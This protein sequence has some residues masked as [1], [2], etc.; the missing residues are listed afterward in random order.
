LNHKRCDLKDMNLAT[1]TKQFGTDEA[2][3]AHLERV[4]WPDGPVCPHCCSVEGASPVGGRAGLHR[5]HACSRQFSVIVGTPLHGSHLPLRL[6]YRAMYLML[7]FTEGISSVKLAKGLGVGQKTAWLLARRIRAMQAS[8][9]GLPI[10]QPI[11]EPLMDKQA[12]HE[13]RCAMM[14]IDAREIARTRAIGQSLSGVQKQRLR[15]MPE[16]ARHKL[17]AIEPKRLR[18][19]SS[20]LHSERGRGFSR[21]DMPTHVKGFQKVMSAFAG[22]AGCSTQTLYRRVKELDQNTLQSK[23]RAK[24]RHAR[25]LHGNEARLASS[26]TDIAPPTAIKSPRHWVVGPFA[27][28]DLDA[29][30]VMVRGPRRY[31]KLVRSAGGEWDQEQLAWLVER[32]RIG[33][34]TRKLKQLT[35]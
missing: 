19:R 3:R 15:D 24:G 30:R 11:V 32:H 21:I 33:P 18:N 4:R 34:L 26:P 17:D 13:R 16:D 25:R 29:H 1:F 10:P 12:H 28:A 27:L 8:K 20:R 6:W 14:A 23:W 7:A 9:G 35:A 31:G 22:H 5:C 2:C